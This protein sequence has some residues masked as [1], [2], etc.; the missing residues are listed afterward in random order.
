MIFMD[1][2][3]QVDFKEK[4]RLQSLYQYDVLDTEREK[5]Y[6]DLT[7]LAASI[8][9]APISRI[10]LV[11]KN[12]QW[13]KS[14]FGDSQD[15]REISRDKT[16]CQYTVQ[17][18]E[19]YEIPDLS[20]DERF[21]HLSYVKGDPGLRFYAGAPLLDPNGNAIGALCVLDYKERTLSDKQKK[22]LKILASDIMARFELRKKNKHL[23]ELNDYKVK[24]MKMLSHDMRSPL[25]GIIGVSSLMNDMV[26]D[27]T[28][29]EMKEMF[30][31]IEQSA[32]QLNQM[33]NEI[34]SYSIIESSGFSLDVSDSNLNNV[35]ANMEKLYSPVARSKTIELIFNTINIE[36]HV[37]IDEDKFEQIFGNLLSN[38]LKFTPKGGNVIC[39]LEKIE[40]EN[41]E[42]LKLI[43][44]DNGLGMDDETLSNL[45]K[46]RDNNS[47]KSGTDGEKSTGIGLSI[48]SY[49]VELHNGSL[50][51][52]SAHGKGTEFKV[53]IPLKN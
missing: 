37:R 31:I 8:C 27:V 23:Q 52:N 53:M 33:I 3:N 24:L 47:A 14:I 48:I 16:V 30:D 42:F 4:E 51:V 11:D 13:S 25:N 29:E 15:E 28:E 19:V 43:V 34:M 45:F 50:T 6:D 7:E 1:V 36:E 46:R 5:E 12:R 38:A 49:F 32:F 18:D 26:G 44:K 2:D 17:K 40:D 22:Q 9:D 21:A 10:N 35:L 20:K 39:I 41:N